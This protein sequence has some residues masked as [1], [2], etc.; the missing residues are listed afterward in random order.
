MSAREKKLQKKVRIAEMIQSD[1]WQT[2][3]TMRHHQDF[4]YR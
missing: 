3:G 2:P 1:M 4:V